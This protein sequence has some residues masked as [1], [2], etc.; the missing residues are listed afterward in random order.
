MT[1]PRVRF[2]GSPA[3]PPSLHLSR[4]RAVLA[5]PRPRPG[6]RC[7]RLLSGRRKRGVKAAPPGAGSG[8]SAGGAPVAAAGSARGPGRAGA[9]AREG[10]GRA[11]RWGWARAGLGRGPGGAGSAPWAGAKR[12]RGR[13]CP[14]PLPGRVCARPGASPAE[15]G[16]GVCFGE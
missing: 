13:G 2:L 8:G 12:R 10:E 6:A 11:P 3:H 9:E 1:A 7:H 14:G 5:L 16:P 15:A 4:S